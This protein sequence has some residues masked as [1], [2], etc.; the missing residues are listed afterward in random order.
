MWLS[1]IKMGVSQ[2]DWLNPNASYASY[3]MA[4]SHEADEL[5]YIDGSY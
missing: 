3:R 4:T 1:Q 5:E 2:L